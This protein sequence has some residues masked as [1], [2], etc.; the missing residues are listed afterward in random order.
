MLDIES[1]YL[2]LMPMESRSNLN[3]IKEL[4]AAWEDLRDKKPQVFN[5]DAAALL[6]CS[7]AE[8]I[9]LE[10]GEKNVRLD[11]G[12]KLGFLNGLKAFGDFLWILRNNVSVLEIEGSFDFTVENG[13]VRGSGESCLV[14]AEKSLVHCFM[15][16]RE[17]FLKR[18]IQIFNDK[19][20]AVFK[21]FLSDES[22]IE[23]FDR[24]IAGNFVSENQSQEVSRD[25]HCSA[26]A[27]KHCCGHTKESETKEIP[28]D[29]F[30]RILETATMSGEAIQLVVGNRDACQGIK[31]QIR[32]VKGMASWFNIMDDKLHMHIREEEIRRGIVCKCGEKNENIFS[33]RDA[34]NAPVLRIV[35]PAGGV[36][37]Q[38]LG[39]QVSKS[40]CG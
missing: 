22:K 18:S 13:I 35:I 7:E 9:A 10:C 37:D 40:M 6:G 3:K 30:K 21:A 26:D 33:F 23:A 1:Q 27:S 20:T 28:A 29:S 34:N 8:L 38:T 31:A 2:I 12:D 25:E 17:K 24:W 11:I 39:D 15:C 32:S 4:K 19:G 5:R 14:A 16:R 36:I